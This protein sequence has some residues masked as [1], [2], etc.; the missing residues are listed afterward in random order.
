MC[1]IGLSSG[2]VS[3]F[4][5]PASTMVRPLF[6]LLPSPSPSLSLIVISHED[7]INHVPTRIFLNHGQQPSLVPSSS[8][9]FKH[10]KRT[11]DESA[12][13]EIKLTPLL[14]LLSSQ[15]S[16]HFHQYRALVRCCCGSFV[17]SRHRPSQ[18]HSLSRSHSLSPRQSWQTLGALLHPLKQSAMPSG[19][20][21]VPTAVPPK[22]MPGLPDLLIRR[23]TRRQLLRLQMKKR[24]RRSVMSSASAP[25]L[26]DGRRPLPSTTG[27][28]CVL[29]VTHRHHLL[30]VIDN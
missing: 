7:R 21:A 22:V 1:L 9:N 4:A 23:R 27:S 2:S 29:E 15:P 17:R 11:G 16:L 3:S 30:T 25:V 6:H 8:R 26:L 20:L 28:S 24:R 5:M 12:I 14:P 10:A 18:R 13:S 19:V